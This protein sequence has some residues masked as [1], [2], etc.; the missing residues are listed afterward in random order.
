MWK[1][2]LMIELYSKFSEFYLKRMI[3][4]PKIFTLEEPMSK[5]LNQ[6]LMERKEAVKLIKKYIEGIDEE[7][8]ALKAI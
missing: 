2:K 3:K 8:L 6:K 5:F 1:N 7:K 4:F